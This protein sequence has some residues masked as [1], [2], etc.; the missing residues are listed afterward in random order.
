MNIEDLAPY[1]DAL[2]E[3]KASKVMDTLRGMR[4]EQWRPS[5]SMLY[6][7]IQGIEA[8]KRQRHDAP[9]DQYGQRKRDDQMPSALVQVRLLIDSGHHVCN[10]SPRSPTVIKDSL[11]V[12]RC[13]AC[14][15]LEQGQV[16]EAEDDLDF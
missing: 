8:K 2:Y 12:L 7:E 14:G 13:K 5:P 9:Q 15:G 3:E 16:F 4:G 6:R 11:C 1:L 10:C